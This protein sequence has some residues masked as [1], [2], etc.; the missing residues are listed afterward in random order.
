MQDLRSN[1]SQH[2]VGLQAFLSGLIYIIWPPWWCS[3]K[4][5]ACQCRRHSF[6]PWDR[7][8][9]QRR[10]WQP[11]AVFLP[12]K[13]HGQRSW[14]GYHPGGCKESEMT[15]QLNNNMQYIIL[16][17]LQCWYR[18]YYLYFRELFMKKICWTLGTSQVLFHA[19]VKTIWN[20]ES[21]HCPTVLY[22]V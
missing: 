21:N 9:H 17:S 18:Y 3:G 19:Q 13:S 2:T 20:G 4:E 6:D 11:I 22:R 10:K 1:K 12:G 14:A 7:K 16:S 5:S 15:G 8:I